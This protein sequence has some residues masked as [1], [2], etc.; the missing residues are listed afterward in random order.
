MTPQDARPRD[1]ILVFEYNKQPEQNFRV[2]YSLQA[3]E[4]VA[5]CHDT[6]PAV[7]GWVCR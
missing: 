7:G 5:P 1:P 6:M 4:K 3:P 2:Y